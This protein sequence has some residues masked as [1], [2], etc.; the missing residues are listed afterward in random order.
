V[1]IVFR[2][3]VPA[4][5]GFVKFTIWRNSV[6]PY[7]P[8]FTTTVQLGD[9]T[10]T[11]FTTYATDPGGVDRSVP[12]TGAFNFR[13]SQPLVTWISCSAPSGTSVWTASKPRSQSLRP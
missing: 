3:I 4:D 13:G 7:T 8:N 5:A 11:V 1:S 2:E 12:I 6:D 9:S 10:G